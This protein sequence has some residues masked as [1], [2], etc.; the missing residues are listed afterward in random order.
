MNWT[1]FNSKSFK[2]SYTYTCPS[3]VNYVSEFVASG[4]LRLLSIPWSRHQFK[5]KLRHT[6]EAPIKPKKL[7]LSV[8]SC[9]KPSYRNQCP[10]CDL[11]GQWILERAIL[12]WC[13]GRQA[14]YVSSMSLHCPLASGVFTASPV[15]ASGWF[16]T[17]CKFVRV[18]SSWILSTWLQRPTTALLSISRS[19]LGLMRFSS[20]FFCLSRLLHLPVGKILM[21]YPPHALKV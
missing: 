17:L 4:Q 6:V 21:F 1:Y 19:A 15:R 16:I 12:Y 20:T 8:K 14:R 13:P 5:D 11:M 18:C 7:H 2:S 3:F 10:K 9:V